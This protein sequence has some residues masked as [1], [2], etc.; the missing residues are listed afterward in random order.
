M[1]LNSLEVF[2]EQQLVIVVTVLIPILAILPRGIQFNLLLVTIVCL[3][4]C[5]QSMREA[6]WNNLDPVNP[7]N[8]N[9][10]INSWSETEC[11]QEFRFRRADLR[12]LKDLLGFPD[13]IILDNRCIC[14][15]E[16]ALCLMIY[17]LSYPS[18][19]TRLQTLFGREYSQLSRIIK[20]SVNLC[21]NNHGDKVIFNIFV[22]YLLLI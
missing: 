13:V 12:R 1:G 5:L 19:L 21:F 9:R 17:R 18:K 20:Y 11:Y 16:Y 8:R 3:L 14:S 2:Q 22:K 6:L 15:G 4:A 10:E 7:A